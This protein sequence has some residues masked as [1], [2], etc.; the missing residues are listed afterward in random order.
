MSAPTGCSE[1]PKRGVGW[2]CQVGKIRGP[3]HCTLQV[4]R[5]AQDPLCISKT[6]RPTLLSLD[7]KAKALDLEITACGSVGGK[8]A[9]RFNNEPFNT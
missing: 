7:S 3:R 5:A 1:H 2:Y 8:F 6:M 9:Q 4:S